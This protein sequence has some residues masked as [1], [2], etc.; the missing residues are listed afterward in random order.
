MMKYI[1][2]MCIYLFVTNVNIIIVHTEIMRELLE[3]N[4]RIFVGR[5]KNLIL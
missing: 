1:L 5:V 3:S 2:L 4:W